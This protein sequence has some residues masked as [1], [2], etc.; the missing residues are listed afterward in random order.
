MAEEAPKVSIRAER[1]PIRMSVRYREPRGRVWFEGKTENISRSGVLFRTKSVLSPRTT[2]EMRLVLP[3]FI[4]DE[5]PCEIHCKGVVV[6]TE[7]SSI[8][9]APP[10]LAVTIQH[11]R[12]ARG[13]Q[14]N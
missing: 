3:A 13:W 6:R 1:Y 9:G 2:L 8:R 12:F 10:A 11:Y 7:Q 5:V 4:K 14:A